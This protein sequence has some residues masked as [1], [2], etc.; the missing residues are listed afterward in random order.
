MAFC[1]VGHQRPAG[2]VSKNFAN[3]HCERFTRHV[4]KF[5][6]ATGHLNDFVNSTTYLLSSKLSGKSYMVSECINMNW[7]SCTNPAENN[8]NVRLTCFQSVCGLLDYSVSLNV[9]QY[10]RSKLACANILVFFIRLLNASFMF[11]RCCRSP[12]AATPVEHEHDLKNLTCEHVIPF[13]TPKHGHGNAFKPYNAYYSF[14]TY[15][16]AMRR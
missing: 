10:P 13:V 5:G 2:F 16:W 7:T 14:G 3:G 12:A 15:C 11:S 6:V 1:E 8:R 9:K 4:S